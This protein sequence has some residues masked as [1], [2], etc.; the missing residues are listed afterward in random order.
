M[1]KTKT[2]NLVFISKCPTTEYRNIFPV[3]GILNEKSAIEGMLKAQQNQ[4][5]LPILSP[6]TSFWQK[7]DVSFHVAFKTAKQRYTVDLPPVYGT[8]NDSKTK[9]GIAMYRLLSRYTALWKKIRCRS[10]RC[11]GFSAAASERRAND[12]IRVRK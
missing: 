3:Y 7:F 6:Y 10:S 12:D 5:G 1:S 11:L 4:K 2:P 8:L 9:R